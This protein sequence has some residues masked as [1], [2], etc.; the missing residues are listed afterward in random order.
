MNIS[1]KAAAAAATDTCA[2]S[3]VKS[4]EMKKSIVVARNAITD[5]NRK[6]FSFC[7]AA[8]KCLR[9]SNKNFSSDKLASR[10]TRRH[11]D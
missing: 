8:W 2:H 3:G 4:L 9:V 7:D 6:L 1:A 11:H 5:D 10:M